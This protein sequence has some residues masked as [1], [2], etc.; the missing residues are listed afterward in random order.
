MDWLRECFK[1]MSWPEA[2]LI[3]LA[4]FIGLLIVA[5]LF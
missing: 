2:L 4:V 1:P 5:Y 3:G